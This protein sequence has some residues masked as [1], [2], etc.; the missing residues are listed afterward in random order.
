MKVVHCFFFRELFSYQMHC[1]S[2]EGQKI[3]FAV[4][5][6]SSTG[7]HRMA[8]I[9]SDHHSAYYSIFSPFNEPK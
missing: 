9:V 4:S 2:T 8:C 3:E 5:S 6:I 7:M 1:R